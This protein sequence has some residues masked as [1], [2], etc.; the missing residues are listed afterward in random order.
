MRLPRQGWAG[1]VFL[2]AA[3]VVLSAGSCGRT[4]PLGGGAGGIAGATGG[5]TATG[6]GTGAGGQSGSG[7]LA[8]CLDRP[9]DL[10]RP[11][12]NGLPCDLVPPTLAR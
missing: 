4:K 6:G 7:G 12:T 3:A 8:P 5:S 11:P 2:A 9:D 1:A 10:P